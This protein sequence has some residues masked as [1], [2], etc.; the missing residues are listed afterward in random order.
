[1]SD[2]QKPRIVFPFENPLLDPSQPVIYV[3]KPLAIGLTAGVIATSLALYGGFSI[4]VWEPTN[5]RDAL[6]HTQM[7]WHMW[8]AKA[9]TSKINF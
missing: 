6:F 1:M 3:S 5:N 4:H 7:F 9:L 2:I 8:S